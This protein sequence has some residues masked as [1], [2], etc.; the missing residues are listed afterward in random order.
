[1]LSKNPH[2]A[3]AWD[4]NRKKWMGH[5]QMVVE[6]AFRMP[7]LPGQINSGYD[8]PLSEN[9]DGQ[10]LHLENAQYVEYA[11]EFTRLQVEQEIEQR[12]VQ[13]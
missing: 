5:D 3:L 1:M 8:S 7:K 13:F 2:P 6:T 11:T 4:P 10:M 9:L 12:R